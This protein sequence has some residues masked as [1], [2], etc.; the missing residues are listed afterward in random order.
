MHNYVALFERM[1]ADVRPTVYLNGR[2]SRRN[3]SR[4]PSTELITPPVGTASNRI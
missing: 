3:H 2:A 4:M 1:V